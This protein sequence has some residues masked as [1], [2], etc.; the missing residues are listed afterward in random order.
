MVNSGFT[1]LTD[2]LIAEMFS[3]KSNIVFSNLFVQNLLLKSFAIRER[4]I[5]VLEYLSLTF[6]IFYL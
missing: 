6:L 3:I 1:V 4:L 5:G 2:I